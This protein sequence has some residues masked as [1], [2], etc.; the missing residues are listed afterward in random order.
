MKLNKK[1][2]EALKSFVNNPSL[3]SSG[4]QVA[5]EVIASILPDNYE[6]ISIEKLQKIINNRLK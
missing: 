4:S 1:E 3:W 6:E 2:I 5:Q